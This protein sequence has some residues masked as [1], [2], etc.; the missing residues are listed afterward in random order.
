MRAWLNLRYT[1]PERREAFARGLARLGYEVNHGVTM[2]PI[3]GDVMVTWNR[4]REGDQSAREF[5][6]R[7]LPV[8]VT[9][10]A[11]WGNDFAGG[12]WYTLARD[13]HNTAGKFPIGGAERWDS[14]HVE[15]SP[16]RAGGETVV[17]PQRGF[18]PVEVAM[19]TGWLKRQS[20]RVRMHPGRFEGRP[21]RD[22]LANAGRVVTWGSAAAVQA[23]MWGIP[24]HSD[25][26]G[27][28]AEQD[29]TDA[30][31][32][33]MCRRLAWA[34]WTLQEIADGEPFARLLA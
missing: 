6:R 22:D 5:T 20:G 8:I 10:N 30:G 13:F 16:W 12:H 2:A 32:L 26:P 7:G 14:L 28:L 31:R 34:Q 19:P 18:G 9:E 33:A 24:V 27:W 17:L 15:L 21:L 1:L 23:L 3:P 4:I 29:N 25:M 11:T